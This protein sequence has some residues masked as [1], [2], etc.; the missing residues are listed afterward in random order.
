MESSTLPT[1]AEV[2]ALPAVQRGNPRILVGASQLQRRVRWVHVSEVS[3]IASMLSG[4]ELIL[5][6][7]IALPDAADELGRYIA[8]L[9]A[10]GVVALIVEIGRR[11]R[12]ELPAELVDAATHNGLPLIELRQQTPFVDITQAVHT[13]ILEARTQEL[14]AADAAHHAFTELAVGGQGP[15]QVVDLVAALSGRSVVYESTTHHAVTCGCAPGDDQASVLARWEAATRD[16]KES[17]NLLTVHVTAPSGGSWGRLV[18]LGA[19]AANRQQ[20]MILDRGATALIISMLIDRE[21]DGLERH[22]HRTLLTAFVLASQPLPEL[23]VHARA[24]GVPLERRSLTGVVVR[25]VGTYVSPRG[26]PALLRDLASVAG[27]T[28][29]SLNVPALVAPL[30]D[31]RIAVLL[32]PPHAADSENAVARVSERLHSIASRRSDARLVIGVATAVTGP[33][34]VH[35]AL[36]QAMQVADA[37]VALPARHGYFRPPDLHLRGLVFALRDEPTVEDYCARELGPLLS[38]DIPD[39]SQLYQF[40]KTYCRFGGNKT[41][42]AAALFVS[43]PVVYDRVAKIERILCVDLSDSEV[44][45]GLHF[46]LLARETLDNPELAVL[47]HGTTQTN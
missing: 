43:R 11:Y 14:I 35:R 21:I 19:D 38:Q 9:D 16:S 2:L 37:A 6:T 5:T 29:Q 22:S 32:A 47:N 33:E 28:L 31:E 25:P 18:M 17:H 15:Q 8:D 24:L 10:A 20:Q 40:L 30:D 34:R 23:I 45:L 12:D 3:D 39:R 44:V 13:M 26:T 7:G 36:L 42:V 46:A 41:A 1:L 4:G 27:A